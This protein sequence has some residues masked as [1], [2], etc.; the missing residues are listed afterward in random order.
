MS[1]LSKVSLLA[2]REAKRKSEWMLTFDE[3]PPLLERE[4]E[5]QGCGIACLK[6]QSKLVKKQK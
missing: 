6:S 3:E 2:F 1:E 5:A 4:T